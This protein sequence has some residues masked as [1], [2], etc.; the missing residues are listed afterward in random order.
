MDPPGKWLLLEKKN[1]YFRKLSRWLLERGCDF[2]VRVFE[3]LLP[4]YGHYLD[5]TP[6]MYLRPGV[7][8]ILT[9]LSFVY[10]YLCFVL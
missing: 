2:N 4:S 1:R 3:G 10:I 5:E 9:R 7:Y 8:S 6:S